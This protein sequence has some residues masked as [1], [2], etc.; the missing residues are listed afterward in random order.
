MSLATEAQKLVDKEWEYDREL[1]LRGDFYDFVKMAW[2]IAE[3][4]KKYKDNWSI[5]CVS[6]HLQAVSAL[7][8]RWVCINVPPGCMKSRLTGLF[9]PVWN[10]VRDK[11]NSRT[12]THSFDLDL[13]LREARDSLELIRSPW[14]QKR[15]GDRFTLKDNAPAQGEYWTVQSG[16][17]FASTTPKGDA[18]GWHFDYQIWDDPHKPQMISKVTLE[19]SRRWA[20]GTMSSRWSD[21]AT[22]RRVCVMQR[23]HELDL[24]GYM[25]KDGYY[26]LRLPMRHE[27]KSYSLPVVP[28]WQPK[29]LD[30]RT[31]EGELLWPGRFPEDYV[32][33]KEKDLGPSGFAGQ[34]QQRPA[35]EGGAMFRSEWWRSW[36]QAGTSTTDLAPGSFKV[37]PDRMDDTIV[38]VD[39]TFK[40][41]DGADYVCI[42]VW[43]RN[44]PNFYLLDEFCERLDF[45]ATC[46]AIRN[47]KA[48]W[49]HASPVLIEDKANGAA[50]ISVLSEEFQDLEAVNPEGGKVARANA[51]TGAYHA[52]NVYQP[53]LSSFTN[54]HRSELL[55]FP[56]GAND[57]R[58]DS[59]SQAVIFLMQKFRAFGETMMKIA[60]GMGV[61]GEPT[62]TEEKQDFAE[63]MKLL[64]G[65]HRVI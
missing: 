64:Y 6:E 34:Y 16:L 26:M 55:A 42:Q 23:L 38:S 47:T 24:S 7:Q 13:V 30:P 3:P 46:Q 25:E 57:D 29:H 19:E 2:S 32:R 40:D 49:P 58:V 60:K 5:G 44:G 18:T 45:A 53:L 50:V 43:G 17:R 65:V 21:P 15:W 54:V 61:T 9:W 37:L 59:M 41:T 52:G 56:F 22:S 20:Y 33:Q 8:L 51:V 4:G 36:V 48:R 35:P 12:G 14:F 11:G 1:G 28:G 39:C 31:V 27:R 62:T 63:M 10:W